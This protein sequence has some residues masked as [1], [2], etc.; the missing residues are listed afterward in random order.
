MNSKLKTIVVSVVATA[1]VALT[2]S[3]GH[4]QLHRADEKIA[5][6][7]VIENQATQTVVSNATLSHASDPLALVHRRVQ[8]R[9][10]WVVQN[11]VFLDNRQMDAK[12]G[13]FVLTP[14]RLE[15]GGVVM[16]QR[17]WAPRNFESRTT[18]PELQT[19]QILVE[20][21]GR[22]APPSSKL[23]EPGTASTG[24]IRQN[25]DWVQ[26]QAETGL[27]LMPVSV[28]QTGAPSEGL[29]RDWPA[30]NLGVDK[31]YGYAFQWFAIAF[32]VAALT[33]WFQFIRPYYQ[34]SREPQEHV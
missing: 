27:S 15:G 16:V 14:L 6:Q 33:L 34:R 26:F 13:F 22:I 28:L 5:L 7:S 9:G 29:R 24:T 8:L 12:V 32:L 23:F 19:P 31:H 11:T 10:T 17:G 21:E 2:V 3:L 20:I 25:L 1:T 4:W 18:L 30:I